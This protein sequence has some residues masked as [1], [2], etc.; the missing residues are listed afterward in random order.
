VS[1]AL[2]DVEAHRLEGQRTVI[3]DS[4]AKLAALAAAAC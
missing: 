1:V 3:A 4:L 2:P